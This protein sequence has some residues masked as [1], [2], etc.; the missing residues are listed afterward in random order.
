[1][2]T[3][4]MKTLSIGPNQ[5]PRSPGQVLDVE[6]DEAADLITGGFAEEVKAAATA[7][8]EGPDSEPSNA[9]RKRKAAAA[10]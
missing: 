5:P 7:V 8:E 6:N 4:K 3:I 2:K 9:K 10:E 1:M